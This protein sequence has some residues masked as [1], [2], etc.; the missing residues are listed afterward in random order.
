MFTYA[1]PTFMTEALRLVTQ[2]YTAAFNDCYGELMT[3]TMLANSIIGLVSTTHIDAKDTPIHD[4]NY[5]CHITAL[6]LVQSIV[7]GPYHITS[8]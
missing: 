7:C 8:L 6:E 2:V 3:Y 4:N 5:S 1:T